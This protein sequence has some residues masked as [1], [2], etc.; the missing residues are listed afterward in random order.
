MKDESPLYLSHIDDRIR[1][2]WWKSGIPINMLG[3][4]SHVSS[5]SRHGPVR[6]LKY[7][8]LPM[9][10]MKYTETGFRAKNRKTENV[11]N[12]LRP[13]IHPGICDVNRIYRPV[14]LRPL[15][16]CIRAT[17]AITRG[18][19]DVDVFHFCLPKFDHTSIALLLDFRIG[20]DL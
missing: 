15:M 8:L 19:N 16:E 12:L 7:V 17:I 4:S 3:I 6:A 20:L 5:Q 9:S 14:Y 1:S 13:S 18:I 10:G 11:Q 2:I